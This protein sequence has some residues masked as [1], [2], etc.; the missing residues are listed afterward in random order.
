MDSIFS[1]TLGRLP[2][3]ASVR[4][5]GTR[6]TRKVEVSIRLLAPERFVGSTAAVLVWFD[7]P[8]DNGNGAR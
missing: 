3:G 2:M 4:Q 5:R 1:P 6:T 8:S 7:R